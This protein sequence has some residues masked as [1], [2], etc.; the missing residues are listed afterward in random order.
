MP[1]MGMMKVQPQKTILVA[2]SSNDYNLRTAAGN[3]PYQATVT[4]K[5]N[6]GVEIGS[7]ST[8]TPGWDTGSSWPKGSK[9]RI[10]NEGYILGKQGNGG[11]GTSLGTGLPGQDGGNAVKLYEDLKIDNAGILGGGGGGGGGGG[12]NPVS[13][14]GGGGTGGGKGNG[15]AGTAAGTGEAGNVG[16]STTGGNGGRGSPVGAGIGGAAGV[17]GTRGEAY[18]VSGGGGGGIGADGGGGDANGP[19]GGTGGNGGKAVALNGKTVIWARTGSRY[20]AYT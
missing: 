7:S 1:S 11:N 9:L 14:A 5:I 3:P 18:T 13:S 17:N 4:C 15:I 19:I 2:A 8:A 12:V 16:T 6:S 20:G 10:V